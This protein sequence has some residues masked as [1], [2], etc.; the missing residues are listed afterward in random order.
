MPVAAVQ[1]RLE[2]VM[3]QLEE[4]P[5]LVRAVRIGLLILGGLLGLGLEMDSTNIGYTNG[6]SARGFNLSDMLG[7][8]FRRLLPAG[9]HQQ[10]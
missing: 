3:R 5:G 4:R 10:S 6:H 1:T 7:G 2:R 9:E 8:F